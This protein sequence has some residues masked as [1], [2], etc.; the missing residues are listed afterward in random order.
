MST[1]Q[2]CYLIEVGYGY[3]SNGRRGFSRGRYIPHRTLPM[4]IE[5]RGGFSVFRSAYR[6]NN[7]EVS[8]SDL[9]GDLYL[10][11]DDI[12]DFEKVRKDALT[13]LSYLKVC[14]HIAEEY[15]AIYFSGNKGVHLIVP[16]TILGIEPMPLLNGVFKSI[17][18]SIKSFT[19]NKT[20]DTQIYDSKRMFR[21]PNTVHEKSRLYK[22]PI[23]AQ[24]LRTL[25][26]EQIK[27]M[28]TQKRWLDVKEFHGTNIYAQQQFQQAVKEYY[29]FDKETK[30]DHRFKAKWTFTP[31]CIQAILEN[32]AE[33]GQRNITI[34]CLTGF[35]KNTGKS[36]TETTDLISEWNSR[37]IKPTGEQ[38]L[39]R[40]VRSIFM[41]EKQFGCS[42]LKTITICDESHCPLKGKKGSNQN[43]TRQGN[44][45]KG[46]ARSPSSNMAV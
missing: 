32:G 17:A 19:P 4:V 34:A 15:V 5:E 25:S 6:Y 35:Y 26:H 1:V 42:T 7:A 16:A 39:R 23:T 40:T 18:M 10:D 28:A 27:M 8:K 44:H 29:L 20:I 12:D 30:K 9:Y 14:Y 13:A 33:E 31:P 41:G 38:E 22:I 43:G 45:Q 21:I 2:E 11:F 3:E 24:E 36:L 37:N 46:Q